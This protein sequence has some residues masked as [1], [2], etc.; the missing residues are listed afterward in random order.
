MATRLILDQKSSGS[1]PDGT[2]DNQPLTID[3]VGGFL[4]VARFLLGFEGIL[5]IIIYNKIG[6]VVVDTDLNSL[7]KPEIK[8]ITIYEGS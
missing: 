4:F 7:E 8:N 2:T 5:Q 1:R 6:V 3:I